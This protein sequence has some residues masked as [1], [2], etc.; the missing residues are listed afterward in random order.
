WERLIPWVY[1]RCRFVVISASTKDD[2]VS[3]GLPANRIDVVLCGLDHC[4]YR[5]LDGVERFDEPT[6]IHFGRIRKYKSI[7]VVIG[8]FELIRKQIPSARLLI[9]GGGP[10][11]ENLVGLVE[12]KG[13]AGSIRFLG[14]VQTQELVGL[15]NRAHLFLNASPKEGW[16]LTV[17]EANACGVPVVAS[18]RPGLQD[19]V[20]DGRTGYLVDYGD[21]AAFAERAVELL[22]DEEKWRRMS[23]AAVEWA[24]SLT[25]ERTAREMETILLSEIGSKRGDGE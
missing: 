22:T 6:I 25:W 5:I 3:R 11:K 19:S 24:R 13:L 12:K 23:A 10:E 18:R 2:L 8:A 21:S 14:T 20:K 1:K 17:V 4:T 7:D 16:G 15:L 9:V